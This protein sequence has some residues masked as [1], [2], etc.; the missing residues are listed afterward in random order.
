MMT[1][2]STATLTLN[3][4][5]EK[6][7]D[8]YLKLNC[9]DGAFMSVTVE[10]I[11]YTNKHK[12]YSV[13]HYYEQNGD[14]MADP[15]M[16][17][18]FDLQEKVFTPSYYKQDGYLGREQESAFLVGDEIIVNDLKLQADHTRFANIWLRNIK[19]QQNL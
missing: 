4:L 3:K 1:L 15:E 19:Q 10:Q 11:F 5:V 16:C 12:I 8:G 17:F 9:S 18:I 6:L 2:N 13:A 7:N 14:L